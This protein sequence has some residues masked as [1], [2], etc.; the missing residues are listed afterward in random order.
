MA[1]CGLAWVCTTV[2][3]TGSTASRPASGSR[4]MPEKKPEAAMLGLPG[5]TTMLGSRMPT[6][7]QKPRRV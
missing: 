4:M 7:S 3:G 5:R 1:A 6:P 2:S